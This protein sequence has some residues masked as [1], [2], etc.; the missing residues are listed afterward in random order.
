MLRSINIRSVSGT[1]QVPASKSMM[2]RVCA[3]ALLH[4]GTTTVY[5]YGQAEDDLAALAIIR[6]LGAAVAIDGEQLTIRSKGMPVATDHIHCGESGLSARLFTPIAALLAQPVRVEGSGS[7]PRRPMQ[8][9]ADILPPLGVALP[10]FTGHIPFTLQGPLQARNISVD[11]SLSSQFISGLLFA[12]TAAAKQAVTLSVQHLKSKPYIDLSLEVLRLFGKPISASA[13]EH[14]VIDPSRFTHEEQVTLRIEGDW[15]SAVFWLAAAAIGG[16]ILLQGLRQDS[17]QADRRIMDVLDQCGARSS[18]TS[19]GL[20]VQSSGTLRPFTLDATHCP[21]LFPVVSVLAACCT[22]TSH[23]SGLHRL[24]HKESNRTESICN[25]LEALGVSYSIAADTLSVTGTAVLKAATVDSCHDHRM[26]MAS[27][28]AAL[29]ADGP[30]GIQ[31]ATAV[32]KSY[33]GFFIDLLKHA[34]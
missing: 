31:H 7:L 17:T 32:Q 21:D 9:L 18:W 11:G 22:G 12:F 26:V 15:S 14:L 5:N 25:L 4:K 1:L 13:Y 23:I 24:T 3:A 8:P 16:D 34:Q 19:E 10:A 30:I 28:L 29:R 6:Q 20:R 2:Q 27:A 33:P